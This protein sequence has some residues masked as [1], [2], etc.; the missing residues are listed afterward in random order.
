MPEWVVA[1]AGGLVAAAT[2]LV[3]AL[4]AWF[5]RVPATV[6]AAIM[7]FGAGVLIATLAYSLV[8]EANDSGGLVATGAGFL[9]GAT[10]YTVADW[11]VSR[12]GASSRHRSAGGNAGS[13]GTALA[14]GA[15][16]D[17]VPESVALGLTV[18]GGG[19]LSLPVLVAIAISNVPEGLS[20][21]AGLKADGRSAKYVFGMW[22]GIAAASGLAALVGFLLLASAPAPAIAF[23]ETVAAGG[24]LAMVANTMIP[25]AF[26]RDRVL[27]GII[28]A[29]GFLTAFVLHEM[30]G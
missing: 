3:G 28:T 12:R 29:L 2:L 10:L 21:T 5:L 14:I 1:G 24:I 6:I 25:E 13:S 27:T 20:S 23:V 26:Q 4:V 30:G 8:E 15:L 7:A 22:G 19:S 11:L 16:I 9:A 17:G 18:A